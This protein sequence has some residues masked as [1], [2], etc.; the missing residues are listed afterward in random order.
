MDKIDVA[1]PKGST[2]EY[3]I[4]GA[5][6]SAVERNRAPSEMSIAEGNASITETCACK[7]YITFAKFSINERNASIFES[8]SGERD[9]TNNRK[10]PQIERNSFALGDMLREIYA[11]EADI[12]LGILID[13]GVPRVLSLLPER[14]RLV[15]L[16]NDPVV[17]HAGLPACRSTPRREFI[18]SLPRVVQ[19]LDDSNQ[20]AG[21]TPAQRRAAANS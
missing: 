5:E 2:S 4:S 12:C 3:N 19:R 10:S 7:V 11:R 8:N 9:G 18:G 14:D 1:F 20:A 13:P 21:G 6:V 16:E 15:A 17:R